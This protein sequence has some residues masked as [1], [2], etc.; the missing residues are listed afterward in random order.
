MA[1]ATKGIACPRG[2][3]AARLDR[4]SDD[5]ADRLRQ[6]PGTGLSRLYS[7]TL[8]AELAH[9]A[10]ETRH[11]RDDGLQIPPPPRARIVLGDDLAIGRVA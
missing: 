5:I 7:V 8:A 11:L 3:L 2:C 4:L 1:K 10:A 6:Q 9:L